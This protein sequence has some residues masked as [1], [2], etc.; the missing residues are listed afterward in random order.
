MKYISLFK[1]IDTDCTSYEKGTILYEFLE[2][3]IA[4]NQSIEI[5][6]SDVFTSSSF[7]NASIGQL[8]LKYD[9]DFLK[10][11]IHFKNMRNED[12]FTLRKSI[13]NA[14]KKKS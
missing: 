9:I 7:F 13:G 12:K 6:M 3:T 5:D 14:I 2:K 10:E 8:I 1:E 4:E 11:R